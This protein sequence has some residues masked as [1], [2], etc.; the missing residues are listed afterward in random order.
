MRLRRH[1]KDMPADLADTA[2]RL[3]AQRPRATEMELDRAKRQVLTRTRR[4][5]TTGGFMR[6]RLALMSILALGVLMS[7]TGGALALSNLTGS[8][9]AGDAVYGDPTGGGVGGETGSGGGGGNTL[10]GGG[11][12]GGGS[13]G[14]AGE[15]ASGSTPSDALDTADQQ[16]SNKDG[17]L[18]F[19]GY[20]AIPLLLIGVALLGTGLV[21]RRRNNSP[22]LS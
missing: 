6:T 1:Q 13:N 22:Q 17:K 7:T 2:N 16:A 10:G 11:G 3:Q 18:P 20:A 19:T 9:N 4:A 5:S 14:V 8:Q 21:L 15:S 12:N